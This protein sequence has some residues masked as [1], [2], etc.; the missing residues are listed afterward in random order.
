MKVFI[1][2]FLA[3]FASLSIIAQQ[4][5]VVQSNHS[6]YISLSTL[7][8]KRGVL[9]TFSYSDKTLK[10]WD[11]KTGL[12]YRTF[13]SEISYKQLEVNEKDGKIY[14]LGSNT[15]IVFSS[16]TFEKIQEYPLERIY[17]IDYVEIQGKGQLTFFAQDQNYMTSLYA[18]NESTGEFEGVGVPPVPVDE[19]I[20]TH[21]FTQNGDYIFV[22]PSY[23][24]PYRYSFKTNSY[25]ELKVDYIA[26]FEN[27]DV[28]R[29]IYDQERE[30]LVY[31]RIQPE[32]RNIVWTRA[33]ENAVLGEGL[34]LPTFG[35][36]SFSK[37]R[38]SFWVETT[39]IPLTKIDSKSGEVLGGFPKTESI[40]AVLDAEDFVYVQIGYNSKFAKLRPYQLE[41]VIS[42]GN[43]VVEP[44]QVLAFQ[45]GDAIELLLSSTYSKEVFSLF[46]HPK[47]TQF[48]SYKTNFRDDFSNGKLI[49]D[50]SSDK[51]FSI[52]SNIDPIKIFNRGKPDSFRDFIENYKGA[53]QFDFSE[54]TK[55]LAILYNRG[56]RVINTESQKELFFKPMDL[57]AMFFKGGFSIAPFN[58]AVAYISREIQADQIAH[59]E[60]Y[61]YDFG[62]K[63]EKWSKKGRYFG[64]FHVNGGK[65]LIASNATTNTIEYIDVNTGNILKSFPFDFQKA[66][67]DVFLSPNEEYLLFNGYNIGAFA[68]HLPT[69]EKTENFKLGNYGSFNGSFV[70]N[71][72]IA[73]P[74]YGG[75]KFI[76]IQTQNEIL[77]LYVFEDKSWIAYTPNGQ[78]DGSPEG[79][80]KVSFIKNKRTIPLKNVFEQFYT[81]KLIHQVLASKNFKTSLNIE[82]IAQPPNLTLTYKKGTRNLY[83]EDDTTENEIEVDA[84]NGTVLLNANPN[85]DKIQEIRLYQNGKLVGNNTRNLFVEDDPSQ[86][87]NNKEINVQL[88]P[89]LN[90][91][92]AIA[93][94]S[95]GT[96]SNPTTLNVIYTPNQ[97]SLIKPQGIQAHVLVIGI[98]EYQNSKY[99]LNYAVA[100]ASGFKEKVSSGLSKITSKTHTYFIKNSEAIKDNI[101]SKLSEIATVAN[102][103]D[104][105]IFY[106]AGH[107]VINVGENKEFYIVPT[108]VVQLYGDDGALAQK[109]ISATQLKQAASGI[110]AQKQLYILD[111][112]QSAGA[113]ESVAAARGAA[114]EKAIAQL[115]RSTGTHWL[116]ASGSQQFAT[117]FDEL[118]HGVF[119]YALL[120][121]L[122]GKADSGDQRVTVNELKAYLESRVPEISEKYKGSPQYPSSFGFGQDFPVSTNQ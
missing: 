72:I 99:N 25:Q 27:G 60:L 18:L 106:Y 14:A 8:S 119:T 109:G 92:S 4:E 1:L 24:S 44:S 21:Y 112:C 118:G 39:L 35:D 120:E 102:P 59:E 12:L 81:P 42:Y 54:H 70:T 94:N 49:A 98:D 89:G 37:D 82:S 15:I 97:Q 74:E 46:A 104:I 57:D 79:W 43:N 48:D 51:V 32:T 10:F 55:Q 77:R 50:R 114:E 31:M 95:Q 111:A 66:Q 96:E 5:F 71:T 41:P 65:E 40:G 76:D 73:V 78:F 16:Q 68:I 17:S 103:Q 13:D 80:E 36:V 84:A 9:V 105:F 22:V 116:T 53:Q 20:S 117:E 101:L 28:L 107:G 85:G 58:N 33:F 83:V 30:R 19:Q 45:N 38:T 6:D 113:L 110:A 23:G 34:F 122:S 3:F 90:E 61:Y 2:G 11:E 52:T 108:D 91:F 62:S 69:Q 75:I 29:S 121:A 87:P 64:V 67:M 100:D 93:L 47:V 86:D 7:D 26:S 63:T 115:A 56:L 88:L